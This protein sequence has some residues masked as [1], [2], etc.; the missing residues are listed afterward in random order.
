MRKR[1]VAEPVAVY[2]EG[3]RRTSATGFPEL[4]EEVEKLEL[5]SEAVILAFAL[6]RVDQYAAQRSMDAEIELV[7]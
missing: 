4:G 3:A 7:A 1:I 6:T 5:L 2:W